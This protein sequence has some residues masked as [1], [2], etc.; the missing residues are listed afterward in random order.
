MALCKCSSSGSVWLLM[1]VAAVAGAWGGSSRLDRTKDQLAPADA[2]Q[3]SA[4]EP[5]ENQPGENQPSE[6][7][8]ATTDPRY[9]LAFEAPRIDGTVTDLRAFEGKVVLIVNVASECGLTPQYEA[10]EKLYRE[11]KDEGF[12]ILAFP[13]NNFGS[14]EPGSNEQIMEFCSS[15]FGVTFP[16][17]EKISVKGDD[18]H[19][20]YRRLAK[21]PLD[22]VGAKEK[23]VGGEPRWNFAK[24]L[25][26]RAGRVDSRYFPKVTPDD[27]RL[28]Q[29]IDELLGQGG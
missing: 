22:V 17:F 1:I 15:K 7:Q 2:A 12:V 5:G 8:P 19:P 11:K 9:A 4:A 21:L 14:Q 24:F 28:T 13:A 29:R 16:M 10:L 23:A 6:N 20:L 3:S 18:A 25:V 27:E 26:D